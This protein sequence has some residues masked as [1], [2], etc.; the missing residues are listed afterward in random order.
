M[1]FENV[2]EKFETTNE[3]EELNEKNEIPPKFENEAENEKDFPPLL[4]SFGETVEHR[5]AKSELERDIKAGREIAAENS[6]KRLEKIEAEEA[7][8]KK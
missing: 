5:T 6:L 3:I 1:D 8:K 2:Y 7:A 4:G